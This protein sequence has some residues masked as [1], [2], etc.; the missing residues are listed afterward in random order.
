MMLH[1]TNPRDD[2][3]RTTTRR[4]DIELE[5]KG[6]T[7]GFVVPGGSAINVFFAFDNVFVECVRM[8]TVLRV[9]NKQHDEW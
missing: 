3:P 6:S 8:L 5:R 9:L 4:N 1:C 7:Y 2:Q